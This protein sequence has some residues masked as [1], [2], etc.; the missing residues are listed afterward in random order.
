MEAHRLRSNGRT[1]HSD[2]DRQRAVRGVARAPRARHVRGVSRSNRDP[3]AGI[4]GTAQPLVPEGWS[5][6][7]GLV[8]GFGD[9]RAAPPPETVLLAMQVHG[10]RI[11]DAGAHLDHSPAHEPHRAGDDGLARIDAEADA[12]VAARPDVVVGV[13]TADCVPLLLVEPRRRWAAAVHAGWRGTLA[14]IATAAVRAAREAGVAPA[15]LLA[16]LGPSIGACCYEVS[17]ELGES[18]VSAGLAEAC[19]LRDGCRPHLDLRLANQVLLERAGV[20][21][22]G[23]QT[24]GPCTRC[25]S[26]RYHSFR[27]NPDAAGRQVSWIGW[28]P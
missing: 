17:P 21:A 28:S 26:D 8:A 5:G 18:F 3:E 27:A 1:Y 25:A 2:P 22:A 12:L 6:I 11:V 10:T 16:A 20:P 15:Q 7:A 19:V 13:R 4:A 14:G 9:R 23:I 24:V